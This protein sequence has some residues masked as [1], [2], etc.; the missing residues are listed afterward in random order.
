MLV[1]KNFIKP[2]S[3]L[4]SG[5]YI[6]IKMLFSVEMLKMQSMPGMGMTMMVTASELNSQEVE[7]VVVAVE[8]AEVAVAVVVDSEEA[9]VVV[10]A[11]EEPQL[12]EANTGYW[13]QVCHLV[14]L[15]K[16]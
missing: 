9:A 11:I 6:L 14:D 13:L 8:A 15:G 5:K 7:A 10:E 16:I 1:Q 12:G 2:I 3:L 4:N